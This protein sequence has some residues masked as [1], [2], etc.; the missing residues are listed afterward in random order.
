[1]TS[2]SDGVAYID[3]HVH[4]WDR[5]VMHMPWIDDDHVLTS[6]QRAGV[7][8]S[9]PGDISYDGS[10]EVLLVEAG[11]SPQDQDLELRLMRQAAARDSRVRGIVV[12][13]RSEAADT[14]SSARAREVIGLRGSVSDLSTLLT[15]H[16]DA[17][18]AMN[19][20]CE[21]LS[22]QET[23]QDVI[24]LARKH[25]GV[26]FVVDHIP[27]SSDAIATYGASNLNN[28]AVKL[29]PATRRR[30]ASTGQLLADAVSAFGIENCMW[31]SN[32][33]V[34]TGE[35]VSLTPERWWRHCC[36]VLGNDTSILRAIGKS[37][38]DKWYSML[39]PASRHAN[40]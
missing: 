36:R 2:L 23:P 10:N 9:E 33:P 18:T 1:M 16:V 15:R 14:I 5:S 11:V 21:V 7:A 19:L 6:V 22:H 24:A 17:V 13:V 29:S 28:L 37:N 31:A 26:R 20:T 8:R 3:A 34:G 27:P 25:T 35:E 40:V 32:W 39:N 30:T 12:P 38:V 4:I